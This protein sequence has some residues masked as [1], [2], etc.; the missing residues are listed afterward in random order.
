MRGMRPEVQ[1]RL[2]DA[3]CRRLLLQSEGCQLLVWDGLPLSEFL[4]L[5]RRHKMS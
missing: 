3:E 1:L 5:S 4:R 2:R